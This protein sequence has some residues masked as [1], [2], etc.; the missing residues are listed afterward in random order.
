M[1]V[2]QYMTLPYYEFSLAP[3]C[4]RILHG[5]LTVTF[6]FLDCFLA[7]YVHMELPVIRP[8]LPIGFLIKYLINSRSIQCEY[9][10][11]GHTK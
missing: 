9:E 4:L 2:Y 7:S 10:Q 1:V 11:H 6:I 3:S 8:S 5:I